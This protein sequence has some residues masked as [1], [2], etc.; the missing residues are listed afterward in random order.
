MSATASEGVV[1]VTTSLDVEP[2]AVSAPLNH[3]SS[4]PSPQ[5]ETDR[6]EWFLPS[7]SEYWKAAAP[8]AIPATP[9][10]TT[11]GCW[12]VDS[13][14]TSGSPTADVWSIGSD[15]PP[16]ARMERLPGSSDAPASLSAAADMSAGAA[17]GVTATTVVAVWSVC[18]DSGQASAAAAVATTCAASACG[19]VG[20]ADPDSA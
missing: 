10:T 3:Q 11:D 7:S 18:G 17:T 1:F 15:D 13:S 6:P 14:W 5:L 2:T 9:S 4:E 19:G 16:R 12:G 8:G 20:S